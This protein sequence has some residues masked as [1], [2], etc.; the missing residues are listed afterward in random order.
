MSFEKEFV[1]TLKKDK[2]PKFVKDSLQNLCQHQ[3]LSFEQ[4]KKGTLEFFNSDLVTK[5]LQFSANE[6]KWRYTLACMHTRYMA[7]LPVKQYMVM[8]IGFSGL[9]IT[10]QNKRMSTVFAITRSKVGEKEPKLRRIVFQGKFAEM[11]RH[12]TFNSTY[13]PIELTQFKGGDLGV[14]DRAEF[15]KPKG[16]MKPSDVL[17]RIEEKG[18]VKRITCAET[19]TNPSKNQPDSKYIDELDWRVIRAVIHD[20]GMGKRED[21]TEYAYYH[22]GDYS[23]LPN[24]AP[25]GILTVWCAPELMVYEEPSECD[26]VGTI[27]V[28]KEGLTSSMNCYMIVPIH[29]V[30]KAD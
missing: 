26:F 11:F 25:Y 8:P 15:V 5:D 3:G 23:T 14:D 12:M 20:K 18:W 4:V 7:R 30:P 27:T 9:R 24:K 2:L 13:D 21:K 17:E 10:K 29:A 22:V 28:D 1:E 19:L 16:L 6:A